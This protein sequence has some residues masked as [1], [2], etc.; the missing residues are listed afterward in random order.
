MDDAIQKRSW[1]L[2]FAAV[3][4]NLYLLIFSADALLSVVEE[5]LRGLTGSQ[6]LMVAR[7]FVALAAVLASMV[8]IVFLVFFPQLPKRAFVPLILFALWAAIGA[9]PL[10][11]AAMSFVLGLGLVLGQLALAALAFGLIKRQTGRYWLV[12]ERLPVKSKLVLRIAASLA[13][14]VAGILFVLP[15]LILGG[16]RTTI[17]T[18]TAGYVRLSDTGVELADRTFQRGDETVRLIGMMHIGEARFYNDLFDSFPNDALVLA[19]GVSDKE[20]ILE[21]NLSYK[22]VARVLGLDQQPALRPS[23]ATPE[24]V[25]SGLPD[26]SPPSN[27]SQNSTL[28]EASEAT[29]TSTGADVVYAD[30]DLSDFSETTI[31]FLNDT[32]QLYDSPTLAI[33]W[34]RLQELS[35]AYPEEDVEIVMADIV[36]KRNER[37]L[38]E[39]NL[40][41][42]DYDVIIIPWGALH[43][44]GIEAAITAKGYEL[45]AEAYRPVIQYETIIERLQTWQ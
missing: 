21:N 13:V 39:F 45:S 44:P 20:K 43:M 14:L 32:A 24:Q 23:E 41:E 40:R 15:A 27:E 36:D 29:R 9:P 18:Q 25:T 6:A 19:E 12:A 30:V 7:T 4:A 3:L 8:M 33:A 11:L 28:D 34:Q 16:L 17:E 2:V 31:G 37:V 1:V 42:E 22:R 5:V 10:N 26:A 38:S 35:V